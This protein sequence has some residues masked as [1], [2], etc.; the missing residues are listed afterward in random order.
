MG[1]CS[2]A[3]GTETPRSISELRCEVDG[4]GVLLLGEEPLCVLYRPCLLGGALHGV[5]GH[6]FAVWAH[7]VCCWQYPSPTSNKGMKAVS[8]GAP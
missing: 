7:R 3:V 4:T 6:L 2:L 5:T 1:V 8:L